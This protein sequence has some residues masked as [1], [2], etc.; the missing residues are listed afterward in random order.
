MSTAALTHY[1][2][3]VINRKSVRFLGGGNCA[4]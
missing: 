1:E 4:V 3:N 2:L